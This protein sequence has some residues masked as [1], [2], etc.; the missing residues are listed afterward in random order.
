MYKVN[1]EKFLGE[2]EALKVAIADND[3]KALDEAVAIGQTR[4]WGEGTV[5]KF[6]ALLLDEPE[7]NVDTKKAKLS[8]YL[9]F[10]VEVANEVEAPVVEEEVAEPVAEPVVEQVADEVVAEA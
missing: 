9:D 1:T 6:Y 3:K 7:F 8:E 4:G 2:I 10:V 5:N